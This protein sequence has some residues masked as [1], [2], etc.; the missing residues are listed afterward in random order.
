MNLFGLDVNLIWFILIFFTLVMLFL[1]G[2]INM[3]GRCIP[4]ILRDAFYYGKT[5]E[6]NICGYRTAQKIVI[7]RTARAHTNMQQSQFRLCYET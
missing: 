5:A 3:F 1:G 2:S 4:K 7:S 6:G